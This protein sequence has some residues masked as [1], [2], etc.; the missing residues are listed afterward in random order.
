LSCSGVSP[1]YICNISKTGLTDGVYSYRFFANDSGGN[2]AI[3]ELRTFT[4]DTIN[5]EIFFVPPTDSNGR[6]IERNY[7]LI[8]VSVND[9]N[10]TSSFIDFNRSL[11]GYWNFENIN[12]T[13]VYDSSTYNNSA[14]FV[15]DSNIISYTYGIRGSYAN[16]TGNNSYIAPINEDF[17]DNLETITLSAWV[18]VPK[19]NENKSYMPVSKQSAFRLVVENTTKLHFAIATVNN[20]WYSSGTRAECNSEL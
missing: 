13:E 14:L 8:N 9:I 2:M 7:T 20:A 1:N 10:P 6:I 18:R 16:F 11:I 12:A 5:P 3:T 15:G 4:I 19:L 17:Y